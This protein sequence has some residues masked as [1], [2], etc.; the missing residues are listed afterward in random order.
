MGKPKKSKN[1]ES[2]GVTVTT[3]NKSE[4]E[5]KNHDSQIEEATKLTS[6]SANALAP[7]FL[8]LAPAPAS[9]HGSE[10]V[11]SNSKGEASEAK[12][13][14]ETSA[15]K[16]GKEPTSMDNKKKRLGFIFMCNARTKPE[17]YRNQVF[18][19]PK[20]K[21]E[22]VEKIKP[23]TRLFLFD[24]DVKLMYGVYKSSSKGGLNLV[25]NAFGGNF[26]AQVIF[27]FMSD[28]SESILL[29]VIIY[30]HQFIPFSMCLSLVLYSFFE[31]L[32]FPFP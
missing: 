10:P 14:K 5:S 1:K 32:Q 6:G 2:G 30:S 17:C 25:P 22:L 12:K 23:G 20:G 9:A 19:L 27:L 18:G 31:P 29:G 13:G 21:L 28:I 3:S 24:F 7:L 8:T 4:E 15:G 16:K 26:P 11:A